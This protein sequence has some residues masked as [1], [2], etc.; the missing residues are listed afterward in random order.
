MLCD[1]MRIYIYQGRGASDN[2][3][4]IKGIYSNRIELRINFQIRQKQLR[5]LK[6]KYIWR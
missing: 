6:K 1:E 2:V 5:T 4:R 3:K